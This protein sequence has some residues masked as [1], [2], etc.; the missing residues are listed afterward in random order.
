MSEQ[1]SCSVLRGYS[2]FG[3][4]QVKMEIIDICDLNAL[5]MWELIMWQLTIQYQY[6]QP[7][8][9]PKFN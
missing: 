6:L 3:R 1:S 5:I 4:I 2:G 7:C 8:I 9:I